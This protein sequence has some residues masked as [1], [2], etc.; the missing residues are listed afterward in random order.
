MLIATEHYAA[1]LTDRNHVGLASF[2]YFF[3][4]YLRTSNDEWNIS[5]LGASVGF[6]GG[7]SRVRPL[8]SAATRAQ[9]QNNMRKKG[10]TLDLPA[11]QIYG[12]TGWMSCMGCPHHE[13]AS[14]VGHLSPRDVKTQS[15]II[16]KMRSPTRL[17]SSCAHDT[18]LKRE[19]FKRNATGIVNSRPI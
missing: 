13:I 10:L 12:R 15:K 3:C 9:K 8:W 2:V 5:R 16:L 14:R 18:F 1:T 11:S 6:L 7:H 4:N 17:T 19:H